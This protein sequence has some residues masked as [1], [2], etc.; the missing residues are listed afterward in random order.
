MEGRIILSQKELQR[1]AV[2]E[3]VRLGQVSLSKASTIM[4]VSYRQAKR[5]KKRYEA[6]GG[7]A[8]AHGSRGRVSL[9][10]VPIEV[11]QR[12]IQLHKEHYSQFNDVHFTEI[13]K[14]RE[15]ID[16]SRETIRKIRRQ[17]G[18]APKRGRRPPVHRSR[19]PRK[20]Q[21]GMMVQW[22]GSPHH[23]FGPHQPPCCLH[24]AVD[25]ALS[26]LVGARFEAQET[27]VGYFRLL[28][29]ILRRHGVP[30]SVY[31]DRHAIFVRTD[32][33]W[34]LEEQLQGC[35][36]STHLGRVLEEL[37]IQSI[38][39]H[40]PQAK[41]RIERKFQTLQDRLL[42]EMA[43]EGIQDIET[44][45]AWLENTFID[46][47]N[48]RFA[49]KPTSHQTAFRPISA[50][51]RY[52]LISFAYEAVVGND[53]AIR[54]GGQILDV[55]PGPRKLS[56]AGKT[57]L[58]RQHLDGAWSIWLDHQQIATG[59]PSPFREP[60]RSWKPQYKRTRA[61][62]NQINQIYISSKPAPQTKGHFHF[63]LKGTY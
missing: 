13:L 37:G 6:G 8:L 38:P 48:Q 27:T 7:G 16:L 49:L 4:N 21:A 50:R 2:L 23:W 1:A 12:V 59:P 58:V 9:T 41:G 26:L 53:N 10:T 61:T 14:E 18:V 35:Q 52:L 30:L 31:H 19:R 46:R 5:L 39:A 43:L 32:P 47:H 60:I 54:L 33:Y 25:D 44:A 20:E 51:I 28:D 42:A 55:P 11:R 57:V 34:S 17:A 15:H 24:A 56:Y 63:A 45:N 22:D 62:P 29:Q 3:Q 40:S 36:F